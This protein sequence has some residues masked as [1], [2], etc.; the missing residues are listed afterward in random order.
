MMYSFVHLLSKNP[1]PVKFQYDETCCLV[2]FSEV[3]VIQA[4][5][6]EVHYKL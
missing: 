5:L 6:T 4:R 2:V 1:A 3:P